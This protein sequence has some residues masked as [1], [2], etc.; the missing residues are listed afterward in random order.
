MLLGL[1]R[2]KILPEVLVTSGE[3]YREPNSRLIRSLR[4]PMRAV[5]R[6]RHM[7]ARMKIALIFAVKTKAGQAR[8]K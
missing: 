5:R 7:V 4:H 1:Y 6:D 2:T 8:E 3:V